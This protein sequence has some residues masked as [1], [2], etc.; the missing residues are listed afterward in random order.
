MIYLFDW[1]NTLMVDFP[2]AQGK[3]CDWEHVETIP[4]ARETLATLSQHHPIYIATSASESAM[5]DVQEAFQRV[6]LDQYISG[7]FCFANLGIAKNQPD[8]Y[9]AVAEQLNVEPNQLTMVGDVPE[10]DIYPALEAGLNV[11]W[12]NAQG[13][14]APNQP[15]PHQIH[16]L[17]QLTDS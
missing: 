7:Y 6:E 13:V 9:L 11:I 5:E 16:C 4:H 14:P 8:F 12:F 15:I 3:M 1:G 10:K 2:H 17:S